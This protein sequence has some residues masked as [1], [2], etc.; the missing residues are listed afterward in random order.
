MPDFL[1]ELS[2]V[3]QFWLVQYATQLSAGASLALT[4]QTDQKG[5]VLGISSLEPLELVVEQRR[6][7]KL[8]KIIE[9]VSHS[10]HNLLVSDKKPYEKS[11]V[12]AVI[13]P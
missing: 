9:K 1:I 13:A 6:L 5:S 12:T 8:L 4:E 3:D 10:H 11:F 2:A 7:H